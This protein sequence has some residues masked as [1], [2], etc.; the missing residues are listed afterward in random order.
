MSTSPAKD[1]K[2]IYSTAA[3]LFVI[4]A[5]L[6]LM[7]VAAPVLVP[8]S[9]AMLFSF[10]LMPVVNRLTKWGV[11]Q[12]VAILLCIILMLALIVAVI[13]YLFTQVSSFV[14]DLPALQGKLQESYI[15]LL[16]WV[17]RHTDVTTSVQEE[18]LR[19]QINTFASSGSAVFTKAL[20][21]ITSFIAEAALI[22]I[23]IFFFLI[24]RK[25]FY[26]FILMIVPARRKGN[27]ALI[28][29]N[30]QSVSFKYVAGVFFVIV[31]LAIMN[32]VG[33]MIIGIEYAILLG[34]LAALL[35]IIPYIGTF[36][37]GAIPTIIAL[38]TK[39]SIG[40]AIAV[41]A[42]FSI[43]QFIE[44][45]LLT[46]NIT[47]SQVKINPL[48]T[49][50]ALLVGNLVWGVAG[51][52]I[53]IPFLGILKIIFDNIEH[54]KPYGYLIGVEKTTEEKSM[55]DLVEHVKSLRTR[56]GGS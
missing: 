9:F 41:A 38:I 50:V 52:I 30:S 22:P 11:P 12:V 42:L 31:I 26:N 27:A 46:P 4:I 3:T 8:L 51:M 40:Y 56:I 48:A 10:L 35:N 34:T 53:F 55:L 20:G 39:D 32:S 13:Y 36:I 16:Q 54:L 25:K 43:N 7:Y 6:A 19:E 24:Y 17:E 15:S 37:G 49:I 29:T 45:N 44:N 28:M 2:G 5:G 1:S 18:M 47:G 21:G 23:F 33:L 14:A